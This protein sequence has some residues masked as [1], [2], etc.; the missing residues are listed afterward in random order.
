MPDNNHE[1]SGFDETKLPPQAIEMEEAILGGI[2]LDPFAIARVASTLSPDAFYLPKHQEIYRVCQELYFRDKPT[3]IIYVIE[4]LQRKELL[5]YVGGRNKLALLIDRTVSAVNI[6]HFANI[7]NQ[8]YIR[9][10][11]ITNSRIAACL[12]QDEFIPLEEAL[13]RVEK[14]MGDVRN[15]EGEGEKKLVNIQDVVMDLYEKVTSEEEVINFYETGFYDLD[16]ILG[17]GVKPGELIVICGRPSMGKTMFANSLLF[18]IA[19][20]YKDTT[21]LIYSLEMSKLDLVKRFIVSQTRIN[22]YKL[23]KRQLSTEELRSFVQACNLYEEID[24]K[25]NDDA[26]IQLERLRSEVRRANIHKNISCITVDYLQI[27]AGGEDS[28]RNRFEMGRIIDSLQ[29]LARELNV[30]IIVLSQL[31]RNCEHRTNKRPMLSD[32]RECGKI[33]EAADVVIGVYRDDYYNKE[34]LDK[35]I[36]EISIL[37][38]RNGSVG[39]V[40]L[41]F[42]GEY[43]TFKNLAV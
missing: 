32:V 30:P 33:E 42:D 22:S 28:D 10:K 13:N 1:F 34:T 12:G 21:A 20:N 31:S 7:V 15:L 19:V 16:T 41:L 25:I 9:R 14:L 3:E 40:K 37:K 38:H 17:G 4:E 5:E 18:N 36:C 27:M 43:F 23:D 24:I 6:D 11:L 8:K 26:N 29:K 2:F 35:D 39:T